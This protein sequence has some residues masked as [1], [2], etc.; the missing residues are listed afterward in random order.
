MQWRNMGFSIIESMIALAFLAAVMSGILL[1]DS[2]NS[3][4][5]D[6]KILS[7]ETEAFAVAF[8]NY[9]SH[10][11]ILLSQLASITTPVT[12]SP[13][14]L[15]VSWPIDLSSKNQYGQV[16]CVTISK[17]PANEELEALMY[18]VGG[19]S[20]ISAK[21]LNFVRS[22]SAHLGSKGGIL[23]NGAI[24]GNS[25]WQIA[26]DSIFLNN[27]IKCGGV[28]TNN[29]LAINLDLMPQWNQNLQ[30]AYS[31][32][33]GEDKIVGLQSMPGHIKNANTLKSNLYFN[34]GAGII[35]DDSEQANP[36][37]LTVSYNSERTGE[38]TLDLGS[39]VSTKL[40]SDSFQP[41]S[42]FKPGD[43]C[44]SLEEGKTVAD[45]GVSDAANKLLAR[46]VLV[47]TQNDLLCGTGNYCYLTSIPNQITFR[48]IL[49]GIQNVSNQFI[50]P[51]SVPFAMN[52]QTGLLG[53]GH[54]YAIVN[55]GGTVSSNTIMAR[56]DKNGIFTRVINCS[57][58]GCNPGI[59]TDYKSG[60]V[61][62]VGQLISVDLATVTGEPVGFIS[63]GGD[64]TYQVIQGAIG[65]YTTPIGYQVNS[66]ATV[67]SQVCSSLKQVLGN[68]WQLLGTQRQS[69]IGVNVG[70]DNSQLGCACERTDFAG[71]NP[72]N[73]KGIA[74]VILSVRSIIISATCSNMPLFNKN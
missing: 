38:A 69:R 65:N 56:L 48:N 68:N 73:Y 30:P 32:L 11:H 58:R 46:S 47:C 1:F 55:T 4:Q 25:G 39:S 2:N 43:G 3:V 29:S 50:C 61:D 24:Q 8:A 18:Y 34:A 72:D 63:G 33:R 44:S 21:S 49:R 67:C 51:K 57:T 45:G 74:A 66:G 20:D 10:N 53:G 37:K 52:V 5:K 70:V 9:M 7:T 64:P 28:L 6:A 54:I 35:L 14:E 36:T 59:R 22:A 12:L 40:V 27:A 13:Q 41:D 42:F 19:S 15:G 23:L 71:M 31:L 16:P 60:I 26:R 17:N 62:G